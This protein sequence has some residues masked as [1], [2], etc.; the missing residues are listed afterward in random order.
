MRSD[1][2]LLTDFGLAD[3]YVGV[4]RGVILTINPQVHIVD[5]CHSIQPQDAFEGALTL[6]CA[7][8]Y[9]PK[10]SIFVCVVDPEVGS[11]RKPIL[12][13]TK[14]Y[15]F[16]APDNGILTPIIDREKSCQI[17]E[18]TND[19]YF[20]KPVS[21]TFHGRDIF[22][23]VAA[24]LSKGL[25]PSRFGPRL[26]SIKRLELP[27]PVVNRKNRKIVGQV[28]HIDHFGNLITNI[29]ERDLKGFSDRFHLNIKNSVIRGLCHSYVEVKRGSVLSII[30]SAGYLEISVNQG[31]AAKK[32]NV[33]KGERVEISS[34]IG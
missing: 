22:S 24:Y 18:I 13:A 29:E 1:I 7:Y 28:M 10:R 6:K 9:F 2:V 20:I 34:E 14:D 4:M 23:P 5:L 12:V 16:V 26:K 30:G 31:S 17:F 3:T 15:F 33:K 11:K 21:H 8:T 32:L 25:L 27:I 19:R